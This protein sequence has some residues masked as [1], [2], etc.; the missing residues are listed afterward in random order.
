MCGIVISLAKTRQDQK[1]ASMKNC[2]K[3]KHQRIRRKE[4]APAYGSKHHGTNA[5]SENG[6]RECEAKGHVTRSSQYSMSE[7]L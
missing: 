7:L 6:N 3:R 2:L 4:A 5:E 1:L